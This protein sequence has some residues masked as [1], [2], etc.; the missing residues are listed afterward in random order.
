MSTFF[1]IFMALAIYHW[2]QTPRT[3]KGNIAKKSWWRNWDDT[4]DVENK[5]RSGLVVYVDY[6]TG[7]EY[8]GTAQGALTPR[9]D[10][11]GKHMSVPK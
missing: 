6:K 1:A 7:L 9:L 2:A 3:P 8:L 4:D 5:V 11:N 10:F